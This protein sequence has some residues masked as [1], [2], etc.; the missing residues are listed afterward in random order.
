MIIVQEHSHISPHV[1]HNHREPLKHGIYGLTRKKSEVLV[2]SP[3][4]RKEP[5]LSV[6]GMSILQLLSNPARQVL[7]LN[8]IEFGLTQI[9]VQVIDRLV[10]GVMHIPRSWSKE[11]HRMNI[12]CVH[13]NIP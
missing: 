10:I 12:G 13:R 11:V 4:G 9:T 5:S 1:V 3:V 8:P 6:P 2:L 7:C